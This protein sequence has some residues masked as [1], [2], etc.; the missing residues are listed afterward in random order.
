[1]HEQ[2]R[3]RLSG[4]RSLTHHTKHLRQP[5]GPTACSWRPPRRTACRGLSAHPHFPARP[6]SLTGLHPPGPSARGCKPS[7]WIEWVLSEKPGRLA[8]LLESKAAATLKRP[9]GESCQSSPAT[10]GDGEPPWPA[11]RENPAHRHSQPSISHRRKNTL[12]APADLVPGPH[13]MSKPRFRLVPNRGQHRR[14]EHFREADRRPRRSSPRPMII[15]SGPPRVSPSAA[16]PRPS[17]RRP[18][19]RAAASRSFAWHCSLWQPA[20]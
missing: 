8:L 6:F 11:Q 10:G 13:M 15:Q 20:A 17:S 1:M 16:P 5:A 18:A 7:W 19:R 2:G 9:T 14:A 12:G 4:S 3:A